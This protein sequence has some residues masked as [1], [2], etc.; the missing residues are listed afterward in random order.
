M[1]RRARQKIP[2]PPTQLTLRGLGPELERRLRKLASEEDLSLN[3][4][5]LRLMQRGAGLSERRVRSDTIGDALDAFIG[6]WSAAQAKEVLAA[7]RDF[8]R[9]DEDL[10]R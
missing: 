3:Q 6:T 5:A 8:E 7:A 10:W 2:T 4:A 9:L 1:T